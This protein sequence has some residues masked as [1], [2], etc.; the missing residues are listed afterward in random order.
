MDLG[1]MR[2]L[3]LSPLPTQEALRLFDDAMAA[4]RSVLVAASLDTAAAAD[5]ALLPPI[6]SELAVRPTRRVVADTGTAASTSGLLARMHG[7][8]AEQRQGELADLVCGNAATVL[9]HSTADVDA[10]RAFEDLGFDSLTAVE[11]R[12]R[13]KSATGLTLSPTVIFD[14]PTPAALAAH[15]D[16]QLATTVSDD[17]PDRMARFNDIARELQGLVGQSGWAADEKSRMSARIQVLLSAL[18]G[19]DS[20]PDPG[21]L[22]DEDISTATESQ[23]FALLDEEVGP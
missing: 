14:H 9:G 7:L 4:G 17:A 8:T 16:T 5:G 12:N 22:F 21:D 6:L 20:E 2:R 19:S 10:N 1:R 11:L 18:T 15:I 13:L 3:G 23:L